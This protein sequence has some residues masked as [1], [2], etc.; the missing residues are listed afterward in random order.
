METLGQTG[1]VALV[2]MIG[3]SLRYDDAPEV[4]AAAAHA[5]GELRDR[6]AGPFL[7]NALRDEFSVRCQAVIALGAIH[8][9]STLA[10]LMA[11]LKDAAPE[12]RYHAVNAV[13]KL[14]D[15]K[16]LKA[17]AALLE[18][19]DPMV[20]NGASKVIEEFGTTVADKGVREIIR[21]ARSR[22]LLGRFIP[23]WVYFVLPQSNMA[24]GAVAVV[25]AASL[26][27]GLI[28]KSTI[29]GPRK[30][31]VRGNV[32]SLALSPDGSTL[33]AER[34]LG[35]VEVWDVDGQTI[36]QQ[37]GLEGLRT[38]LFRAKDGIVLLSNES[39]VP[40]NLSGIPELAAGWKEHTQPIL[41]ACV[42]PDG[43][44]AATM[45]KDLRAVIWDLATGHKRAAVE[46]DE[47]FAATL[48]ISPDGQLLATSNRNGQVAVWEIES[49]RRVKDLPGAKIS[50]ALSVLSMAP[51]GNWLVGVELSGGLRAWDL[52]APPNGPVAKSLESRLPLRAVALRFLSDSKRV[53]LADAGGEVRVWDVGSGESQALCMGDIDQIDGFALSANEKRFAL[54]GNG[55]SAVLV[56]DLDSGKLFKKLDQRR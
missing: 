39:V 45:G 32:Q 52:T 11:M 1:D 28:I 41:Q 13:A 33:I 6:A 17:V 56:Y 35:M 24:R 30:V 37:V 4:R 16:T 29:G 27:L 8:E 53:V 25:L 51:D 21:R 55:N 46:L 31:L 50:K 22:D 5:L 48:T 23:K 14:K 36:R 12:V 34:T 26:L 20:R 3:E 18:D 54:G 40:W 7:E 44:F 2:A 47:R 15:P 9:R 49:G 10:A 42:T 43:K 19:S 38:P